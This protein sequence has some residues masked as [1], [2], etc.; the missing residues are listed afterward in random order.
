MKE[1]E[2]KAVTQQLYNEL[3]KNQCFPKH[4]MM[5]SKAKSVGPPQKKGR[6][7]LPSGVERNMTRSVYSYVSG[8]LSGGIK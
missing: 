4:S 1:E 7:K 3:H 8:I 5:C 2:T 6:Q